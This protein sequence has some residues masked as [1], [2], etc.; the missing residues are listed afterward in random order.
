[1]LEKETG[2]LLINRHRVLHLYEADY[3][4]ILK[5]LCY[6]KLSERAHLDKTLHEA[7]AISRPEKQRIDKVVLMEPKYLYS[8]LSRPAL[9]TMDNDANACYD[10]IIC[11]LAM[12]IS[13]YHGMPPNACAMQAATLKQTKFHLRTALGISK[14]HYKHSLE[15]PIY[16]SGQDSNSSPACGCQLVPP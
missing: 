1:M 3:N 5:L 8:R 2:N 13:Q 10:R 9:L 14:Q 15:K 11:N 6:R 16:G 12:L 4:M 7:Q